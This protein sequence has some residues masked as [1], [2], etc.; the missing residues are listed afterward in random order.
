MKELL[1]G[2]STISRYGCSAEV[3]HRGTLPFFT[4]AC[5]L[6]VALYHTQLITMEKYRYFKISQFLPFSFAINEQKLF[7]ITP[8]L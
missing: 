4:L 3:P 5:T 2:Q 8:T 1:W 7:N 6:Y